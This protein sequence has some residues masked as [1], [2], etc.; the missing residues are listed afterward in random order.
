M[1]FIPRLSVLAGKLEAVEGVA[2][3]LDEGDAAIV[4][5]DPTVDENVQIEER[6][7]LSG[8]YSKYSPLIGVKD[9]RIKFR[10]EVK[11]SGT[12]GTPPKMN[13]Y[14]EACGMTVTNV[15][16]TSDTY[17]FNNGEKSITIARWLKD[18]ASGSVKK[19]IKGA[20]GAWTME[21]EIG[22]PLFILFDFL[23]QYLDVVDAAA[24][25]GITLDTLKPPQLMGVTLTIG[26]YTPRI[27]KVSI[28]GGQVVSLGSDISTNGVHGKSPA[29]I[30]DRNL[31]VTIDPEMTSVS[32][33]D[34]FGKLR[35]G[36]EASFSLQVGSV[37]GNRFTI[38]MPKFQYV[39][40]TEAERDNKAILNLTG[41]A[42]RN[43]AGNDEFTIAFT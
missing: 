5:A 19:S 41:R 23:G 42:N 8:D 20:R 10:T 1:S 14:L 12:A 17:K 9:R 2:E 4:I 29:D 32:A 22:K 43:S 28:S 35:D 38:T 3:T 13:D 40:M 30:T 39:G 11:G 27:S 18:N 36:T 25:S 34:W 7:F 26:G 15:P 21:G 33:H 37:A 24:P 31:Q 6:D 16:A